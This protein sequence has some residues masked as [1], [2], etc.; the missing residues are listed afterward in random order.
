MGLNIIIHKNI[1]TM[2]LKD[3]FT[4]SSISPFLGFKGG[5]AALFFY[6]LNRFSVDLDFDLLEEDKAEQVFKSIEN[7]LKTYGIVK[8]ARKKRY[9]LFFL[10]SYNN[11]IIADQNIK[12]EINLR[13]FG[14]RF[15]VKQYLG[16]QMQVMVREDMVANKLVAMHERIG[17]T[18]RDIYD[19]WF[20]LQ[21]NWPI[22]KKIIEQRSK[23]KYTDFLQKCIDDLN[24]INDKNILSGIG[25]LVNENQKIWIKN[26]LKNE[27]IFLL[28]LAL[29]NEE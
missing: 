19:V 5:T 4:D 15:E 3:I 22:N 6:D 8:D 25:E 1:L 14:S 16:I 24:K 12:L 29:N 23:I 10:L 11:K 7:I 26:K 18:N 9:S 17:K 13:N 20:F 2:I 28:R 21:N 27:T